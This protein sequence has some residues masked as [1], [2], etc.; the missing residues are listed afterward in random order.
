MTP[1][2][3]HLFTLVR[4]WDRMEQDERRDSARGKAIRH[5]IEL[6][7]Q[8]AAFFGG[9]DG[10]KKLHDAAEQ[11]VGFDNSVGFWINRLWDGIGGWCS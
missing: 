5:D 7:G 10:M 8:T 11:I 6:I 3:H 2:D 1:I 9:F 4:E